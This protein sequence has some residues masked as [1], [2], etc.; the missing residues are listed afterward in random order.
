[1]KKMKS[2]LML[3]A[4]A[5]ASFTF[6]SC[7]D[8]YWDDDRYWHDDYGWYEDYNQGGWGWNQGDWNQGSG[9]SQNS[10]LIEEAQTLVGKWY[11]PVTYS[12]INEDGVSRGKDEFYATMIFYQSGNRKNAL[13]GSGVEIDDVYDEKGEVEDSQTLEFTWYIDNNGDIYIRYNKS[14]ATFVLDAGASQTGFHLGEEQGRDRYTFYGY[15]IG[16]GSAKGDVIT[17]DL[18]EQPTGFSKKVTRASAVAACDSISVSSGNTFGK[19][20]GIKKLSGA[21]KR[22]NDRR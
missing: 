12:Y 21:E 14:G 15:M 19:S 1:M 3:M 7:D 10:Q 2:L 20:T 11:G 18:E 16:V 13:S 9:G 22:L 6:T 8:D 5:A 4:I 17:F